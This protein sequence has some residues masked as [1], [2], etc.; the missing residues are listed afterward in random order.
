MRY[1]YAHDWDEGLKG[2]K[3]IA[4]AVGKSIVA[5]CKGEANEISIVFDD[6]EL[7]LWHPPDCCAS[8]YFDFQPELFAMRGKFLSAEMVDVGSTEDEHG[9]QVDEAQL[10]LRTD[11]ETVQVAAYNEHNGYYSGF[12]LCAEWVGEVRP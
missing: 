2:E 1:D 5:I 6:G 4:N 8:H 12:V 7:H 3:G 10:V 11:A 9:E